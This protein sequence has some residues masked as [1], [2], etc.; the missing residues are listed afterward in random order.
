MGVGG[1]GLVAPFVGE[2]YAASVSLTDVVAPP[3][4]VIDEAGR[5]ALARR[6]VRNVV[7]L[8]MPQGKGDRYAHAARLLADW[9]ARGLL[10]PDPGP[11]LYVVRQQF[12]TP[13]GVKHAR[14][15]VIAAV[16]AEPFA[17]GRVKPHERTHAGP[18][19]DRLALL[20]ATETMCE[21]LLML[22]RDTAGALR[23]R[24][25][26]VAAFPPLARAELDSVDISLWRVEG[27]QALGLADAAGREPLYIADGHHRYETAVAYRNENARAERTL[28]LIVPVSDPGLVVL[29][30]HRMI[31]G[32]CVD[33]VLQRLGDGAEIEALPPGGDVRRALA[34]LQATGGGCLVALLKGLYRLARR[35][36]TEPAA[37]REMAPVVR[38]LD[39]AWADTVVVPPLARSAGTETLRYTPDF[40]AALRAVHAGE[41]GA[42]VLLN[43][44]A[45]EQ[46]LAVADAGAFMPPKA[47]FFT[48][49]VPSGLVFLRYA[50]PS[51]P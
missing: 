38:L 45:V 19:Q 3:Y 26:D 7:H 36:G 20:R 2:R 5:A 27:E 6:H 10:S 11:G 35:T 22:S 15:G 21:A 17:G 37:W 33:D 25:A 46:V 39:V 51:S 43:P 44:P 34:D 23:S 1:G 9:R 16:V 40:D 12:A 14:T 49:K 47:T 30:T 31:P 32:R 41:A 24:L 29:P 8:I 28:G 48:P 50:T 4:D 18:K 13:D 42:A